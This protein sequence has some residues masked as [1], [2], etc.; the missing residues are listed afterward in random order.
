MHAKLL[1]TRQHIGKAII[2]TKTFNRNQ[3]VYKVQ[4]IR[5]R[6]LNSIHCFVL[7]YQ[8]YYISFKNLFCKTKYFKLNKNY[9]L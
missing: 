9:N 1:V 3:I 5:V 8:F 7:K 2:L 6:S 4:N